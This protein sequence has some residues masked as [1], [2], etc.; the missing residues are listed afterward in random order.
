MFERD[1]KDRVKTAFIERTKMKASS[2]KNCKCWSR[3]KEENAAKS[4]VA[5]EEEFN[6]GNEIKEQP[7][8]RSKENN[9]LI[10]TRKNFLDKS[11]VHFGKA[12]S[13]QNTMTEH[14]N[15]RSEKKLMKEN[16]ISKAIRMRKQIM[17]EANCLIRKGRI[18]QAC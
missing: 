13:R 11:Q 7:T 9:S 8:Y 5:N 16:E 12:L 3:G 1:T 4:V 15:Y 18:V 17:N 2:K 14:R 6:D 10:V